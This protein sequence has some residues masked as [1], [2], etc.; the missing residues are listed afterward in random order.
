MQSQNWENLLET[1]K[2]AST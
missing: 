1:V 2:I